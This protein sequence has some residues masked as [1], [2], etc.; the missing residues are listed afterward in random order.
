VYSS[1]TNP[2]THQGE[3]ER[4]Q[5][6]SPIAAAP[7]SLQ[8]T[9]IQVLQASY[10]FESAQMDVTDKVQSLVQSGQNVRVG[11]HLFG[12]DPASGK[13]K[14]LSVVFS[15]GGTQHRSEIREGNQ[16]SLA[17]SNVISDTAPHIPAAP[18]VP[19]PMLAPEGTYF[20][21]APTSVSNKKGTL[22]ALHDGTA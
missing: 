7:P 10:G 4:R 21:T 5:P 18:I 14:T 1:P 8:A 9:D 11:N 13:V 22:V 15:S 6:S 12:K 20:L 2:A 19:V 3:P 17:V 16:L